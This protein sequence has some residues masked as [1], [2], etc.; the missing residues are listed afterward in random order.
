MSDLGFRVGGVRDAPPPEYRRIKWKKIWK[1]QWKLGYMRG[2]S[3][4]RV[5]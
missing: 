3:R 1:P 5:T 4:A 2:L